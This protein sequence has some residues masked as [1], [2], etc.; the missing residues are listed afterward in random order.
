VSSQNDLR[1]YV[2]EK[3]PLA[4][5]FNCF[6]LCVPLHIHTVIVPSL[7]FMK[8]QEQH[9]FSVTT[10]GHATVQLINSLACIYK[11][12][13]LFNIR[14]IWLSLHCR[15]LSINIE[16]QLTWKTPWLNSMNVLLRPY[17]SAFIHWELGQYGSFMLIGLANYRFVSK[18]WMKSVYCL[19]IDSKKS[20]P[21]K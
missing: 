8:L 13:S 9:L 7:L 15:L 2:S 16:K 12:Q 14:S 4:S 20:A 21:N 3:K 17:I 19:Y 6:Y 1:L 10:P 18:C 5:S 11:S